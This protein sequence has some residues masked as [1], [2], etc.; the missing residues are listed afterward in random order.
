MYVEIDKNKAWCRERGLLTTGSVGETVELDFSDDWDG[1]EKFAV[2]RAYDVSEAAAISGDFIEIPARVL[3]KPDVQLLLGVY[4]INTEGTV[5][6]PTVYVDLGTIRVG[7]NLSGADNYEEPPETLYAQ[8]AERANAAAAS[9]AAAELSAAAAATGTPTGTLS[10]SVNEDGD[11][12]ETITPAGGGT[13]LTVNLGHVVGESADAQVIAALQ[14][15]VAAAQSTANT[16][17]TNAT[18]AQSAASAAQTAA[19]GAQTAAT[20]AQTVANGKQ[21]KRKTAQVLLASGAS[22]WTDIPAAGVTDD[23]LVIWSAAPASFE[24]AAEALV[25]MT[26]QGNGVVSFAASGPTSAAIT[27]NLAIFD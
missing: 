8:I 27:I 3:T 21:A 7:A 10:F 26:A 14:T 17:N 5:I 4:G 23:N 6:I 15:A 20:N 12:I 22:S 25:R 18:N 24:A 13:P 1:L 9:A 2:F 11:L 16:A 19:S